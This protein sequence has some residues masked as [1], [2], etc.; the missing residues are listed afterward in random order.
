MFLVWTVQ[1]EVTWTSFSKKYDQ[2]DLCG[3]WGMLSVAC[4][5]FACLRTLSGLES[6]HL[7]K[8]FKTNILAAAAWSKGQQRASRWQS[9]ADW[10]FPGAEDTG[11]EKWLPN[12]YRVSFD[13]NENILEL[14][15]VLHCEYTKCHQII[16]FKIDKMVNF[17]LSAFYHNNNN[18]R[19][20]FDKLGSKP[21][22]F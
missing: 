3:S 16:H 1:E 7:S 21:E 10:W 8:A 6:D 15:V 13:E 20:K 18:F 12:G 11:N 14:V 19:N 17:I 2:F 22:L 5:C 9:K 4:P